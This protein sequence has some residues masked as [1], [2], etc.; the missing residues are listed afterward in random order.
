MFNITINLP[1]PDSTDTMEH[2]ERIVFIV[3]SILVHLNPLPEQS[4]NLPNHAINIVSNMPS[5]CLKY[6]LWTMPA[7]VCRSLAQ[8]FDSRTSSRR[9]RFQFEVLH[10]SYHFYHFGIDYLR[11]YACLVHYCD[12]AQLNV[13]TNLVQTF[14]VR[15]YISDTVVSKLTFDTFDISLI[16]H[17]QLQM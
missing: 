17:L 15:C 10:Y 13:G 3:R 5:T 4:E 11:W 8:D 6:L 1:E 2:C 14:M 16:K 12:G 9:F 7:S